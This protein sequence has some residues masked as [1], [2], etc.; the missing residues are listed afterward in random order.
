MGD[1]LCGYKADVIE[2]VFLAGLHDAGAQGKLDPSQVQ[3]GIEWAQEAS[4][5][6]LRSAID[7]LNTKYGINVT[8]PDLR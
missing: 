7:Q 1:V 8:A 6:D 2:A 3:D 5:T 4:Q